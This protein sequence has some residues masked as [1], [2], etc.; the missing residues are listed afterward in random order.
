MKK[1][2]VFAVLSIL[3]LAAMVAP[4]TAK[5]GVGVKVGD[6]FKYE[7]K[8]TQ[9]VSTMV[10]LQDG[11]IGPLSLYENQTDAIWYNVT[12]ITP[13]DGGDNVTFTVQYDW[14]NG[15]V[16]YATVVENVSTANTAIFMIGANMTQGDMVSDTFDFL[17]LGMFQYPARYINTT[18]NFTNPEATRETNNLTYTLPNLLGAS[19]DYVIHYDRITGMRLYYWNHGNVPEIAFGDPPQ[20]AYEYTVVWELVDSS[21]PGLLIPDLTG[22]ILLLTLMLMTIPIVL[23]HRRRKLIG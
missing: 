10:F 1:I 19:Y 22:P 20:P 13:G 15:S 4:A 21:Y 3:L 12:D 6:W 18:F 14:K 8:V 11:Y 23:L 17:N 16:T 7:A 9:W 5:L 2:A